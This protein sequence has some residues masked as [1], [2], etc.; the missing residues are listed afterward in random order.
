M[1]ERSEVAACT[2]TSLFRNYGMNAAI[3]AFENEFERLDAD[4]GE[5]TCQ[6]VCPDEHDR[7]RRRRIERVAHANGVADNNIPLERLD[8]FAAD[9]LVLERP[10]SGRYP[11]RDLAAVKQRL[12]RVRRTLNIR[13][14]RVGEHD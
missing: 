3:E 11:V 4:A 1:R 9:D 7:T 8:L 12:D 6:G 13:L 5:P 14:R 10:E 2:E